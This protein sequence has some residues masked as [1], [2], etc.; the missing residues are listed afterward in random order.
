VEVHE[1]NGAA[2]RVYERLGFKIVGR[3]RGANLLNN[4]RYDEIIMD[5]LRS[6]FASKHIA[7]FQALESEN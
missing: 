1:Y 5:L 7:R 4:R 6:E 3:L 2:R